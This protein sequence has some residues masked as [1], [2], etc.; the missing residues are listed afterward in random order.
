MDALRVYL[1]PA[2]LRMLVLGFT[3]GLPY[4]LVF[5]T[6]SFWLREA[7]ID[8]AQI[9]YFS[10]ILLV[11]AFK[12]AWSPLVDRLPIP[13]A[14]RLL[15]RRRSWLLV[16]EVCLVAGLLWIANTDPSQSV[17]HFAWVA[18]FIATASATHD[19]ALDAFRIES[20]NTQQQAALAATYQ[21]G[22]R[23]A[24]IWAGAGTLWI[25]ARAETPDVANY[26]FSAWQTAYVVMALSLLPGMLTVLLSK[27]PAAAPIAPA[28]NPA[29]W[30]RD[31]VIQPFVDF[32]QRYRWH[33]VSLLALI[34]I[35]RISDIVMGVM[36]N[37]F[38]VD[39][40]FTKAEVAAVTKVYGVIMTLVGTFIGGALGVRLGIMRI[41]LLGAVLSAASNLLFSWLAFHGHDVT[42]LIAVISADNLAGG[43]ATAAFVAY[44][45]SLTNVSYS[46]TQY[47]LFSSFMLLIPKT[48]AGYS[49]A[50]VNAYGYPVFF[51]ATAALGIPVI[52]LLLYVMRTTSSQQTPESSAPPTF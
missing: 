28:K 13:V 49:G 27:E 17:E 24:L 47:A 34:A 1:Q 25:A 26:Q 6:L 3:A 39:T 46:A 2:S 37:S 22:Y 8:R 50:F 4:L 19:I 18:L 21:A 48:L 7:G 38:Y 11:Y 41:M 29:D 16:T 35:Y 20:A 36:A 30:I 52:L 40:G 33:A 45:S 31:A 10:W 32:L 43:I 14:T 51:T 44:L 15:G 5:G 9:G 23:L 12:W 42:A